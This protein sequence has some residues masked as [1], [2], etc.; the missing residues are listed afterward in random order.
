MTLKGTPSCHVVKA[1]DGGLKVDFVLLG[2][3][4]RAIDKTRLTTYVGAIDPSTMA[5][6]EKTLRYALEL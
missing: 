6:I 5:E 3:Q 4:I 2:H 1:G